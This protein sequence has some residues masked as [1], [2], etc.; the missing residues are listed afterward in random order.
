VSI[1]NE[2][3]GFIHVPKTGGTWAVHAMRSAGI[4]F[5][6]LGEGAEAHVPYD[7]VPGPFKFGFVREPAMWYR[8]HW[9]HKK[10]RQDYPTIMYPFDEAVRTSTDFED[11]VDRAAVAAPGYLSNLYEIFL[12]PPGAIEYVGRQERLVE[13]LV[14]AL[15]LAGAEFDPAAIRATPPVNE[16]T[17]DMPEITP[18]LRRIIGASEQRA[19][20]RFGYSVDRA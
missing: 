13:D 11:F 3:F 8:S 9:V 10:R 5:Q 17:D 2:K 15:E 18:E 6:S 14:A 19:Y 1:H 4:E 12:G 20:E 7:Q 16:G